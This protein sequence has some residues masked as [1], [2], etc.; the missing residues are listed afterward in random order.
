MSA[1]L[2]GPHRYS[3]KHNTSLK[4]EVRSL[5]FHR[6]VTG[7]GA[8]QGGSRDI[9]RSSEN[10]KEPEGRRP[11]CILPDGAF[12]RH[13]EWQSHPDNLWPGPFTEREYSGQ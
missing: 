1:L 9:S 13:E 6:K 10:G 5:P 7:R 12:L 2:A 3:M 11:F 8:G 4:A